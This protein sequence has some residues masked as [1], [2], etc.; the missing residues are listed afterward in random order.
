MPLTL[1]WLGA[2]RLPVEAD[3]LR[4]DR[5]DGLAADE[6]ARLRLPVGNTTAEL[7]E[8]FRVEGRCDAELVL[9]GDLRGLRRLGRGMAAGRLLVE[10][11]V[12][13]GLATELAGGLVELHGRAGDGTAAGMKGGLL[14]IVGGAGNNLAAARPGERVGMREGVIL[15]EGDIGDDAGLAMRRGLIAVAGSAGTGLGR[16]LVA[17]SILAFGTVGRLAGAGMK[18][19]T[20]GLFGP[21]DPPILPSFRLAC[22]YRPP[23][24]GLY[25]RRL[26]AWGFPIPEIAPSAVFERYNGDLL[27]GGKG[28]ILRRVPS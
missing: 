5:L 25:L 22:R 18:R 8:L 21:D 15:V 6:A 9:R 17:G 1:T 10:G 3:A 4:P 28:E 27:E 7:G 16:A 12:G 24:L 11:D 2:T 20:I 13:E 26:A 14:R 23:F 19:G